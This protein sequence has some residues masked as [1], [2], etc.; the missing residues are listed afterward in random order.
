MDEL[1]PLRYLPPDEIAKKIL[2]EERTRD[3]LA[4]QQAALDRLAQDTNLRISRL[5][6]ALAT[7]SVG[8]AVEVVQ[9][10]TESVHALSETAHTGNG[11]LPTGPIITSLLEPTMEPDT[12]GHALTAKPLPELHIGAKETEKP[13]DKAAITP[14]VEPT[15]IESPAS[16]QSDKS[17]ANTVVAASS[18]ESAKRKVGFLNRINLYEKPLRAANM[19]AVQKYGDRARV[20]K[21]K[22]GIVLDIAGRLTPISGPTREVYIEERS[23]ILGA[24]INTRGRE[25]KSSELRYAIGRNN[26]PLTS[27]MK[28]LAEQLV[29]ASGK[30]IIHVK[31]VNARLNLY[32]ISD[33]VVIVDE[34]SSAPVQPEQATTAGNERKDPSKVNV[35]T[36]ATG[37][38][39]HKATQK[40]GR[41]EIHIEHPPLQVVNNTPAQ[42]RRGMIM[43]ANAA[44]ITRAREEILRK[45]GIEPL[46]VRLNLDKTV[47]CDGHGPR[48]S[49]RQMELL[50]HLIKNL[51]QPLDAI[52]LYLSGY[53]QGTIPA[54]DQKIPY[55]VLAAIKEKAEAV[56]RSLMK[57][58]PGVVDYDRTDFNNIHIKDNI[59]LQFDPNLAPAGKR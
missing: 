58:L 36:A 49:D 54:P 1:D 19:R 57:I 46:Y 51:G 52:G 20:V 39:A 41:E 40:N 3:E 28:A 24:L 45:Q 50:N 48:L 11:H 35:N 21:L 30:S 44:E 56:L 9:V 2:E 18:A 34:R 29:D 16:Q 53:D 17:S 12:N 47:E 25:L 6:S 38:A 27:V 26:Y 8:R 37:S 59:V 13:A 10:A 32:S 22:D 23:K 14:A 5:R 55:G 4:A 7:Q 31:V 42:L 43:V 33:D 15:S